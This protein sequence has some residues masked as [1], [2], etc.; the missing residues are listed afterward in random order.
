MRPFEELLTESV[1]AHGHLCAG[2]VIGVR[3][4]MLGCKLLDIDNPKSREWQKNIIVFIEID[5]CMTDAVQSVTGC[6]LGRRTM[7]F[8]DFG[9]SAATFINLK[10]NEAYRVLATESSR[11]LAYKYAVTGVT[12][13]KEAQ[14]QGYQ[15]MPD[16]LLFEATKVKV[17][18]DPWVMPGPPTRKAIC[19]SCGQKVSDGREIERDGKT[20]C[21]ICAGE[22]YFTPVQ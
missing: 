1:K 10:T 13:P 15:T 9:I 19:A 4:A 5:R 17:N 11:N 7:K 18:L 16:D 6:Q 3:M 14:L 20:F 12:D 8:K 21:R 22:S 2:Q